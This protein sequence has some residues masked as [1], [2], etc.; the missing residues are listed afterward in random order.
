M[1]V[2]KEEVKSF[3]RAV[4]IKQDALIAATYA[5]I[6]NVALL[7]DDIDVIKDSIPDTSQ[8]ITADDVPPCDFT[9]VE[10]AILA[11]LAT[12]SESGFTAS[13]LDDVFA[14]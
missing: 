2:T 13:D 14:D 8:F 3:I 12:Q 5:P 4:R 6:A 11:E 1:A 9:A 7:K 10:Q